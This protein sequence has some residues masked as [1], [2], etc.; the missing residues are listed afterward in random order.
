MSYGYKGLLTRRELEE[1][2]EQIIGDDRE[3]LDENTLSTDDNELDYV[4]EEMTETSESSSDNKTS[5]SAVT[6]RC[7]SSLRIYTSKSN[8]EWS[9]ELVQLPG[10][11]NESTL[12]NDIGNYLDVKIEEDGSSENKLPYENEISKAKA[13]SFDRITNHILLVDDIVRSV[14]ESDL[15]VLLFDNELNLLKVFQD[16]PVCEKYLSCKLFTHQVKWYNAYKFAE[17]VKLDMT[18]FE[19]KQLVKCLKENLIIKSDYSSESTVS[20]LHL[21]NTSDVK[22]IYDALRLNTK[23]KKKLCRIDAI[24]NHINSQTTLHPSVS[25]D[26]KV[27]QMVAE[28]LGDL[29]HISPLFYTSFYKAHLLYTYTNPEFDIPSGLYR[30]ISERKYGNV[31]H[32]DYKC[33]NEIIFENRLE[34]VNF[35]KAFSYKSE[36]VDTLLIGLKDKEV[37]PVDLADLVYRARSYQRQKKMTNQVLLDE[38]V[39]WKE[40]IPCAKNFPSTSITALANNMNDGP[41]RGDYRYMYPN[42][43]MAYMNVEQIAIRHY[44]DKKDFTEGIHCEGALAQS[45]FYILFW[46]II[47]TEDLPYT[48]VCK[49]QYL[50]LDFYSEEFYKNREALINAR[51]LDIKSNWSEEQ[52][53]TYIIETWNSVSKYK[54]LFVLDH[55]RDGQKLCKIVNC[56]GRNITSDICRRLVEN[57]RDHR[58]GMPDLFVYN[59]RKCKFVEVKGPGDKLSTKQKLWINFLLSIGADAEVCYVAK[60]GKNS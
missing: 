48:F 29:I 17:N 54:S 4:E 5:A 55:I 41:H 3:L 52:L 24:L 59:E 28:K 53:K 22:A 42:G 46:D 37:S 7:S 31:L 27:R 34:F 16:L 13:D 57:F 11:T 21:L 2:E 30:R 32:P 26:R 8:L 19:V 60:T 45:I 14:I 36:A 15:A 49:M 44:I 58:A 56:I 12:L 35:Y 20:L 25:L 10:G 18:L 33:R 40:R 9:S 47:Y 6:V 1:I 51:L 50:P 38:L 39:V 43:D 23:T